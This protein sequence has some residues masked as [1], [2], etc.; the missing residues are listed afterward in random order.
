MVD[1]FE[2]KTGIFTPLSDA[3]LASFDDGQRAAY[4]ALKSAVAALDAANNES[5]N[6][7]AVNKQTL[8]ALHDAEAAE[9]KKPKS[10]FLDEWRAAKQQYARDH[11]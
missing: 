8:S 6:A 3:Q 11:L 4:E 2:F 5:E 1:V 10:N 9:A 7:T